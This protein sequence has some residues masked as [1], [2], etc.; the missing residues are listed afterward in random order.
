MSTA[1]T[2]AALALAFATAVAAAPKPDTYWNVDDVRPGM[3]GHGR[4][5]LRGTINANQLDALS[6]SDAVLWIEPAPHMKLFD[7]VSSDIVAGEGPPNQLY[8]QSLG[9][10]GTGVAVPL[11][12]ST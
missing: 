6:R 9:Y 7:E 2:P 4:T 10:D 5:V 1:R 11:I 12:S 3:T 8:T